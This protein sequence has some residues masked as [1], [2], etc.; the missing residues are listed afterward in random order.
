MLSLLNCCARSWINLKVV[1]I[2]FGREKLSF[3]EVHVSSINVLDHTWFSCYWSYS[4]SLFDKTRQRGS[5]RIL[6]RKKNN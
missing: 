3:T 2:K 5:R 4:S 6:N 1:E